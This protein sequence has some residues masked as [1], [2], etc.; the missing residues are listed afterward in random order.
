MNSLKPFCCAFLVVYSTLVI[1]QDSNKKWR[2]DGYIK[3]MIS[4]TAL[5]DVDSLLLDNL[6]HNRLNFFWYPTE[7]LTLNTE[8]RTRMFH[9]DAVKTIPSYGNFIDVNN[10][11]F[12][13]SYTEDFDQMVFHTMIDRLYMQWN[14][15]SWQLKVGRQRINW[16]VNL[17]WNPNDIFNAYSLY[18]FDYEERPGTDALR[19]QKFIGYAG[20]YEIAIK[21][22]DNWD[23]FTVAAM[24]KWNVK[25]YDLQV[26]GGIMK[27]NLTAGVGWAG[28]IGWVGFKGESS[29][30]YTLKKTDRNAWLTSVSLDYSLPNS[31][32]FNGSIF[33]N[34]YATQQDNVMS[35]NSGNSDV[36]SLTPYKWNTFLQTSYTFH[37]LF[38][39]SLLTLVS[40]GNSGLFINPIFTFSPL[41]NFDLDLIGQM[42]LNGSSQNTSLA[43]LRLKYSF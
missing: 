19:F 9:G 27:N 41:N 22:A 28:S 12:D 20:G 35:L 33:Y 16:G 4:L 25:G 37:P 10:D 29:Y 43:Y 6:I 18:D 32:Y 5:Q 40:P 24:Y 31:L 34:S 15:A 13:F 8:V 26:L 30:F 42:F 2:L 11:F 14:D 39:G 17:A 23:E 36:R 21:I 3:E 38:S 7:K 1:A